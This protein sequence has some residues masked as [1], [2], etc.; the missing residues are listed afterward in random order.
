MKFISFIFAV[1]LAFT[2][3]SCF[4]DE[5]LNPQTSA[6]WLENKTWRIPKYTVTPPN[7][8][9]WICE[10]YAGYLLDFKALANELTLRTGVTTRTGSWAVYQGAGGNI[11]QILVPEVIK[12]V[13]QLSGQW[14]ILDQT[15]TT[16]T[17]QQE[18]NGTVLTMYLQQF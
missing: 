5:G 7:A 9:T 12:D 4:K 15:M 14:L 1:F 6:D 8:P 3:V 17:L 10:G 11:L 13:Y 18:V 16:L 2:F